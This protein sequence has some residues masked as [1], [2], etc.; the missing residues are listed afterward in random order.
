M[1][2]MS[3][4][5]GT[6]FYYRHESY[7]Q[8]IILT[9]DAA[10]TMRE[11]LAT[12][13]LTRAMVVCSPRAARSPLRQDLGTALG[14]TCVAVFAEVAEHPTL[15]AV[16]R[17]A[18]VAREAGIDCL[19][20]L[21]GGSAADLAK[22]IAMQLVEASPLT[23]LALNN[24]RGIMPAKRRGGR[25]LPILAVPT[26]LSGAECTPG[27]GLRDD[28]GH[29]LLLRDSDFVAR[30]VVL[31]PVASLDVPPAVMMTTG[32]NAIAHCVEALYSRVRDPVSEAY[33][34]Q[35]FMLLHQG[36]SAMLDN[37]DDVAARADALNGAHLAGR[38]IVNARTGIH[39]AACH[40]IGAA[41]VSHGVAN[42][43]LLPHSI[44]FNALAGGVLLAGI[45]RGLGFPS[46]ADSGV[47]VA[48]ALEHLCER[49]RLPRRLRD[50]GITR[51]RVSE[52]A[53]AVMLEPGLC[54]NPRQGITQG[55]I[56]GL[57]DAAW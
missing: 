26:T 25:L 6:V 55:D 27:A 7:P 22:G 52:M 48:R 9:D 37:P 38:A 8:R 53:A 13:G 4:T 15:A 1:D 56:T 24:H 5:S 51:E 42:A 11:E 43:I 10:R 36:L 18:N 29:K 30:V 34:T 40:V 35:G 23:R 49:A 47:V 46:V 28:N 50:V 16:A 12:L 20:S 54:F 31:D 19:I 14:V 32:M 17:G 2:T 3:A 57:L 39:H 21:G 45:A 41:G 33:A 44:V